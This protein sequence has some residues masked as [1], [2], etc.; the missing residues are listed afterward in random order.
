[1]PNPNDGIVAAYADTLPIWGGTLT[2]PLGVP[3]LGGAGTAP[4]VAGVTHCVSSAPVG[5][6]LGGSFVLTTDGTS[7][8]AGTIATVTF[9]NTYAAAPAAVLVSLVDTTST[10]TNVATVIA[11]VT[12]TAITIKNTASMT[13]SHTFLVS[14]VVITS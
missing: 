12:A 6:D 14:Y 3:Q 13:A 5:H 11:S 7:V 1:M 8:T 2:G 10:L 4:T 9:G